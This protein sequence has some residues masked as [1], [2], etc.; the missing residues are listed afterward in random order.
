MQ[1][2]IFEN[3]NIEKQNLANIHKWTTSVNKIFNFIQFIEI[4]SNVLKEKDFQVLSI[5]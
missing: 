3:L 2:K 1:N 5:D 4:Y